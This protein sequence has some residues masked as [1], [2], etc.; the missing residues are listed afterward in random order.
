MTIKYDNKRGMEFT[1]N[2]RLKN[3]NSIIVQIDL[4]STRSPALAKAKFLIPYGHH[5][6]TGPFDFNSLE[7]R[8]C[9]LLKIT[10]EDSTIGEF[11]K[12]G[13]VETIDILM[14]H[15]APVFDINVHDLYDVYTNACV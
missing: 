14:M 6:F 10:Y 8:I 12:E 13:M 1:V 9:H 15:D 4:V 5:G 7:E 3:D 11:R 2:V